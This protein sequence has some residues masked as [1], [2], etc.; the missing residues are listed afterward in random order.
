MADGIRI[1]TSKPNMPNVRPRGNPNKIRRDIKKIQKTKH[2]EENQDQTKTL[3][4]ANQNNNLDKPKP[5]PPEPKPKET[6]PSED[7]KSEE[8]TDNQPNFPNPS[9][10]ST[11][12]QSTKF[13]LPDGVSKTDHATDKARF[14]G[15]FNREGTYVTHK[16][17]SK[18]KK[19]QGRV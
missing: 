3:E 19:C 7:M 14:L 13:N 10:Y 12:P 16:S 9:P 18:R 5:N 6:N 8:Q 1:F 11:L 15:L 17:K 2:R 4:E